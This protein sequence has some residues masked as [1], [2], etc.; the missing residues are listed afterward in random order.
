MPRK[1]VYSFGE[2]AA[3]G[4][5]DMK[6]LLGGKGAA[7]AEMT[8]AGIPVPP[9]FTITT[10]ACTLHR[11]LGT[12]PAEVSRQIDEHLAVLEQ[13][14]NRTF[15]DA[16][17]P[18]L[19][20]VRSGAKVS[21]PGMMDTV[22]NLGLN[23][24]AVRGLAESSGDPRFALDAYRRFIMMYSDVVLGVER[25]RFEAVMSSARRKARK[26]TDSQL[27]A[28]QLEKVV[29]A[30][31]KIVLDRTGEP[32]PRDPRVQLRGAIEAVFGSWDTERAR[33]YR[34]LHDI[35]DALGT[36]CNVQAM[37]F[38]NR[39]ERSATGVGFTRNPATGEREF[40]GE[41]LQNAQGEDV[42]AGIRTPR[43]LVELEAV[44][45]E[46]YRELQDI[47]LR[48]ER[49][50]GD[51]QDFEFTIEEGKLFMLQTRTG[52]R[53]GIAAVK[54]AT[55]MVDEG[56][57]TREEAVIRVEPV[58]LLQL[59]HPVFD[60][61]ARAEH[62]VAAVG[63]NASPG[64]ACGRLVF[65]SDDAVA[66]AEAGNEV[67]LVR[68]E[69]SP[70]DIHGMNAAVGLLTVTGGMTSHAAVVGRQMGKPAVVGCESLRINAAR[71]Q[72]EVGGHTVERGDWLSIDGTTGEVILAEVGTMPSEVVQVVTG[73]LD[74]AKSTIF[75]GFQRLLE[76]ADLTRRLRVRA[77]AD[78][79]PDAE[80][81]LALGAEGI[82]LAR[83]EHMFFGADRMPK[84]QD[85]I[86]ARTEAERRKALRRLLPLQR[87]DFIALF[88]A[89]SGLPVT[90]RTLDPPL[91]EFLPNPTELKVEIEVMKATGKSKGQRKADYEARLAELEAIYERVLSIT[92]INPMLGWRGCRLTIL[93]PEIIEMQARAL[94]EAAAKCISN[95]VSV[96]PEIMIPLVGDVG[97]LRRQREVVERVAKEVEAK[98]GVHVNYKIGT[99]IELPRA[100][101][102][103]DKI[104][105]QAE[106][107]SFGTND[108]TQTT[109]GFSRDDA[110][111]FLGRYVDEG[112]LPR[113]PFVSIDR[114][115]VGELMRI[116]VSKG[117]AARQGIK[118]GICG[119][120]G[121]D[122]QSV[123]FCH[124]LGLDYVS[125]S[126]YRIPVARLA[127]A[128]AVLHERGVEELRTRA[129]R[130]LRYKTPPTYH[131]TALGH[132][133]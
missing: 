131:D 6:G 26:Q 46:A 124:D 31:E 73:E 107:F 47:A 94:F 62:E 32:F 122:P 38:G 55:D 14:M 58:Q 99:M 67:I 50:Y 30:F 104:A 121:G 103:A 28:K 115:G 78:T 16:D 120:H 106:F 108:L 72:L 18:L 52:K 98:L 54:V 66:E 68:H 36:A 74:P 19:V 9:G 4:R 133:A 45:P 105:E 63:I 86:L 71:E 80:V 24:E 2:G 42:V 33:R 15:G 44:L 48:L 12:I 29:T 8:N 69:T 102:T 112:I 110:G 11:E 89:M 75:A 59:L 87:R 91:H 20:S 130:N 5:D 13:R 51:M 128:Q 119:E 117:R 81:A 93:V 65:T 37:V 56:L 84:M 53:T 61:A 127:A 43:L 34:K 76:W 113:N 60:P 114:E 39:G 92:E 125:C 83:T 111:K 85:M 40:Y 79:G 17:E 101:V 22:L 3:E 109:F 25:S 97:E 90:I 132:D 23:P 70:D 57:I 126:P 88:K 123:G 21:M 96:D 10:T 100:A 129:R 27:S 49:H 1:Y 7:L 35:S 64:A 118:I 41:F 116:A 95:G 77:N 82:G